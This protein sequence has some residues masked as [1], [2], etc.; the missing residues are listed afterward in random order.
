MCR[1]GSTIQLVTN[2]T[3]VSTQGSV[4]LGSGLTAT[5]GTVGVGAGGTLSGSGTIDANLLTMAGA[6][7]E[8]VGGTLF[9]TPDPGF[10]A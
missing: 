10:G 4:E 7:V 3:L 6:T 8:S 9:A 2:D 1:K 5:V